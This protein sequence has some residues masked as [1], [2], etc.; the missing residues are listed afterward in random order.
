MKENKNMSYLAIVL[1]LALSA[2][3]GGSKGNGSGDDIIEM[4]SV[5]LLESANA[6]AGNEVLVQAVVRS[7]AELRALAVTILM[8]REEGD[9]PPVMLGTD[10]QDVGIGDTTLQMWVTI[11]EDAAGEDWL[12][13]A[14][15][16]AQVAVVADTN[17]DNNGRAKRISVAAASNSNPD[18]VLQDAIC[19][20]CDGQRVPLRD[21]VP[22]LVV[23]AQVL[24][25]GPNPAT[26][27][28]VTVT[29]DIPDDGQDPA[30]VGVVAMELWNSDTETFD[31]SLRI[32]ELAPGE[33][34]PL[35]LMVRLPEPLRTFLNLHPQQNWEAVMEIAVNPT[36]EIAE[37]EDR[38][39]Q[40]GEDDNR[41]TTNVVLD[42][43]APQS[44]E[45]G[46]SVVFDEEFKGNT[47][48]MP[49]PLHVGL[50]L[51]PA[52]QF[53]IRLTPEAAVRGHA[54]KISGAHL[55]A[56]G[57][58]RHQVFPGWIVEPKDPIIEFEFVFDAD[59]DNLAASVY[60]LDLKV[61]GDPVDTAWVEDFSDCSLEEISIPI[62][63]AED[64]PTEGTGV[65]SSENAPYGGCVIDFSLYQ[66]RLDGGVRA[67]M[68][69]GLAA[70]ETGVSA[71][72]QAAI[73]ATLTRH[74]TASL[75]VN[76]LVSS[77]DTPLFGDSLLLGPEQEIDIIDETET[78]TATAAAGRPGSAEFP[79]GG[80]ELTFASI[81]NT[82]FI[83]SSLSYLVGTEATKGL[84]LTFGIS[85]GFSDEDG[86]IW[87]TQIGDSADCEREL[88]L[89][90]TLLLSL[91]P[92]FQSDAVVTEPQ[93]YRFDF[94]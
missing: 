63:L 84:C 52:Q 9:E 86:D 55:E 83:G 72:D 19:D 38:F 54:G 46:D 64:S 94:D 91:P 35:H 8:M 48:T 82:G 44:Y 23:D 18:I 43:Y 42:R 93:T 20:R 11:P 56:S 33:A 27:V 75:F 30:A 14:Q 87:N 68:D 88:S 15:A 81:I 47:R 5:G 45:G 69:L 58:L 89:D 1:L 92:L 65:C 85:S 59:K 21:S 61:N 13:I 73:A 2:C 57:N 16:D 6:V 32:A 80:G 62:I 90:S 71:P 50:L 66:I 4:K 79:T 24:A 67:S 34:T 12:L 39:R 28:E 53:L 36:G 41:L 51:E 60:S 77:E 37:N 3:G 17:R 26:N 25:K 40:L 10:F 29:L 49:W 31:A 74:N 7:N 76:L 78:I 22:A 70:C